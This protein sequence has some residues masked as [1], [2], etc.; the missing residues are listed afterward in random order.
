MK[1]MKN[2][3]HVTVDELQHIFSYE[4]DTGILRWKNPNK[5]SSKKVGDI[6]GSLNDKGYLRVTVKNKEIKVHRIAW[7]IHHGQFP[8][9]IIDHKNGIRHDN[10]ISNIREATRSDNCSNKIK[11]SNNTSGYVGVYYFPERKLKKYEAIISKNKKRYFLGG[12]ETAED[13]YNAYKE[14]AKELHGEFSGRH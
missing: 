12:F 14:K 5:H 10:R 11:Q 9:I 7:A 2:D 6:A 13:A 1:I 4:P 3:S 8:T